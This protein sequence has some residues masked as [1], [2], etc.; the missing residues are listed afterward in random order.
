MTGYPMTR[1]R[2]AVLEWIL[3]IAIPVLFAVGLEIKTPPDASIGVV[4]TLVLAWLTLP[5]SFKIAEALRTW[6]RT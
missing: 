3:V 5:F 4:D 2:P 6:T 1:R